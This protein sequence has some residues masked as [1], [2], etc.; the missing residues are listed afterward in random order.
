[1]QQTP[2]TDHRLISPFAMQRPQYL[3]THSFW[4][5]DYSKPF[6]G[7]DHLGCLKLEV[8]LWFLQKGHIKPQKSENFGDP[9]PLPPIAPATVGMIAFYKANIPIFVKCELVVLIAK[10]PLKHR[11]SLEK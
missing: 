10:P 6:L 4:L 2:K 5:V 7:L 8:H 11:A 3:L 9:V 1:M